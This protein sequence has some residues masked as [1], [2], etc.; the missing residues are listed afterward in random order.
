MNNCVI[1]RSLR[2]FA[3]HGVL[4]QERAVGA[5]FTLSISFQTDFSRAMAEDELDGT[6]SYA[7][8]FEVVKAETR[9]IN[10]KPA[11]YCPAC[12]GDDTLCGYCVCLPA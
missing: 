7:D 5:Y 11:Y 3:H 4:P 8:V 1:L 2:L 9:V 12:E 10:G 6:I